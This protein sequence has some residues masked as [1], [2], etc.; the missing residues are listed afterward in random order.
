MVLPPGL[1]PG[2]RD[3]ESLVLPLDEGRKNLFLLNVGFSKTLKP[4]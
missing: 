4:T 2:Y 1:E 3:S